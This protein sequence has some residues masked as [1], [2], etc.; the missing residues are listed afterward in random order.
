MTTTYTNT[1]AVELCN[2][3]I[4]YTSRR[5]RHIVARGI[6]A[7]IAA[8]QLTC[9]LGANGT[10]KSTLLRTLAAFQPPLD[11][12]VKVCGKDT[13]TMDKHLLAQTIGVVLTD[14]PDVANMTVADMVAMGRQPYTGFWGRCSGQDLSIAAEAM[15]S[16]GIARLAGRNVAQLSDG[17]R[18]KVMIAKALAQQT[19]VIFLDEPTAFLD[20]PS[21]VET[22]KTLRRIC[23]EQ[24]KTVFMSTH[25]VELA[26][27]LADT[28]WLMDPQ[29]ITTGSPAALAANGTI[30]SFF[31]P[32]GIHFNAQSMSF[33]F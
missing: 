16:V 8:G 13:A 17:E 24:H 18:Q 9:L 27:R 3:A 14:R 22:M 15:R 31:S 32:G 33:E 21:K 10:G 29:G 12:C 4:G 19:P 20:F 30:H 7:G 1:P 5:G 2:L 25:D 28:L 23:A 6:S 26:I 11:G